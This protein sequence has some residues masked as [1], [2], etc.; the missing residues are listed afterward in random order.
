MKLPAHP[1][2]SSDLLPASGPAVSCVHR[3]LSAA[4]QARTSRGPDC[5][6][7]EPLV[8]TLLVDLLQ[9]AALLV[10]VPLSPGQHTVC[11]TSWP[12]LMK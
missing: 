1:F 5:A 2:P 9:L 12:W 10:C 8:E 7:P 4:A 3:H 6:A 11:T